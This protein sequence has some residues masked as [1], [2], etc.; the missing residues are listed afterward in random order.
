VA[1]ATAGSEPA[2]SAAAPQALPQAG[3]ACASAVPVQTV[4]V[5][6]RA[7]AIAALPLIFEQLRGAGKAPGAAVAGELLETVKIYND[8]AAGA[9]EELAIALAREYAAFCAREPARP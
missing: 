9:D 5:G 4:D 7:V 8:I 1:S 6:G 2:D 3:C